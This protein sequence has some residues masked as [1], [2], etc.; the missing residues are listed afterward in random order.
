MKPTTLNSPFGGSLLGKLI[1]RINEKLVDF[2]SDPII[3]AA[4]ENADVCVIDDKLL[5]E[6]RV[7]VELL[8]AVLADVRVKVLVDVV[9]DDGLV[10]VLVDVVVGV[11]VDV[12]LDDELVEDVRV[13]VLVDDELLDDVLVDVCVD[14]LV[15]DDK[16]LAGGETIPFGMYL[17]T[18]T[19]LPPALANEETL[20]PPPAGKM[21]RGDDE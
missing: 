11:C 16:V 6:V 20:A 3:V 5:D 21:E 14:V 13:D 10:D 19:P 4:L 18:K 8:D 9:L 1:L 15:E 2:G 17:T 7:D 12:V